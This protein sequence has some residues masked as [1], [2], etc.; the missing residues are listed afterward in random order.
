[1]VIAT[2]N[3]IDQ[4][5]ACL[6]VSRAGG[7]PAPVNPQMS[8]A[9][10]DLVIEDSGATLVIRDVAELDTGKG[11]RS[12]PTTAAR[13]APGDVAALFYTSGTTGRPK[14]AELTHRALVGQIA[15]AAR[16]R[17]CCATTRS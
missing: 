16:G 11:S 15:A 4:F 14:G 8:D 9:E 3:G 5:L 6:A 2:E 13:P 17:S 10:V 12:A 7:L 1:M